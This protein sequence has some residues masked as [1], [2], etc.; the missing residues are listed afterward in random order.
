MER[1]PCG[2][3]KTYEICCGPFLDGE[4]IPATAEELMRSR[5]TAHTV[6]N[7]DYVVETHES[8]TRDDID[9]EGSRRWA[10]ESTWLG[11]EI[12]ATE[13]GGEGDD[14]ATV[15]FI[16]SYEDSRGE[17]QNHHERSIFRREGTRWVFCE[18]KM[19]GDEPFVRGNCLAAVGS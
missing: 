18:G 17:I 2:N 6:A 1:C 15:E 13:G 12:V 3:E 8:K 4:A 19:H 5:Y 11:L 16:A 14:E 9:V 7:I 10:E